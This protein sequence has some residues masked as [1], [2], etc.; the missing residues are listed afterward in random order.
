MTGVS[1]ILIGLLSNVLLF[2][3][4]IGYGVI[5]GGA[6]GFVVSFLAL[7]MANKSGKPDM[8]FILPGI[9][10]NLLAL[11]LGIYFRFYY[12]ADQAPPDAEE[13]LLDTLKNLK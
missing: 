2:V 7:G 3:P 12:I 6:I 8:K 11:G 4:K 1:G 9:I 13:L 5:A 10:L